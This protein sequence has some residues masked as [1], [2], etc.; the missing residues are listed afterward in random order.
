ML[1]EELLIEVKKKYP[2][3]SVIRSLGDNKQY[4]VDM[5]PYFYDTRHLNIAGS[6]KGCVLCYGSRNPVVWAEIV[7]TPKTNLKIEDL[8][9]SGIYRINYE[10]NDTYMITTYEGISDSTHIIGT[11]IS[12]MNK[13][14]WEF[15]KNDTPYHKGRLVLK[16]TEEEKTWL[17]A[18]IKANKFIPKEEA[19][20]VNEG[21]FKKDDYIVFTEGDT[22]EDSCFPLNYIF[23]QRLDKIYL[24]PYLDVKGSKSNG[25][26]YPR[27]FD[28]TTTKEKY[29]DER[30][31]NTWR[32]A[33]KEEIEEYDRLGRPFDVNTLKKVKEEA[34][35][36]VGKWYKGFTGNP[37]N[38][39]YAKYRGPKNPNYFYFSE[40]INKKGTYGEYNGSWWCKGD[41]VECTLAEIQQYLPEGNIDR[42]DTAVPKP[43]EK[44]GEIK[45]FATKEEAELHLNTQP[46]SI[47]IEYKRSQKNKKIQIYTEPQPV[48]KSEE[49]II[50]KIR[51]INKIKI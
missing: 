22:T 34:E 48:I 21:M 13:H 42:F 15:S 35:F 37:S 28:W 36:V 45:W 12:N 27:R 44:W 4:I 9:K 3:G 11:F 6:T 38:D 26:D 41:I 31:K 10:V 20:K 24:C 47:E 23:K 14:I 1:V 51:K 5:D 2:L 32:Y 43:V 16:A 8:V 29:S 18:C 46:V 49:D 19:L 33:T 25:W 30:Y 39:L 7:S 17:N 40:Y 50:L